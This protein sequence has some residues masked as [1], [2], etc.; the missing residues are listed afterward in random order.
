MIL[1]MKNK[2]EQRKKNQQTKLQFQGIGIEKYEISKAHVWIHS[3]LTNTR[4]AERFAKEMS[5]PYKN[6]LWKIGTSLPLYKPKY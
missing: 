5:R 1:P 3:E 6:I 4:T 2:C